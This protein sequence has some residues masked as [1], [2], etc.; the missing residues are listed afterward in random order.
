M[1]TPADHYR[2]SPRRPI[3]IIG[4]FPEDCRAHTVNSRGFVRVDGQVV[5]VTTA[6]ADRTVGIRQEG[7]NV[8]VWFYD[9]LLGSI[10]YGEDQSVRPPPQPSSTPREGGIALP[11]A[12][13][14]N[15]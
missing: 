1:Q 14:S 12:E 6:L 2:P 9:V 5:Y 10:V 7:V 15:E 11:A 4:G 3:E 8:F 13:A